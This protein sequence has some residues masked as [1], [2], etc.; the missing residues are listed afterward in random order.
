MKWMSKR[1][2]EAIN[3]LRL[4]MKEERIDPRRGLGEDLF[5]FSSSLVPVVNV[6]LFITNDEKEL[7][8][9]WRDDKFS[10][11]GWH[12]PGGCVR[13]KETLE[14]RIVKTAQDDIGSNVCFDKEPIAVR[15][16]INHEDRCWL[17][18]QLER[19][20][21]ISFLYNCKL[22]EKQS[23][24]CDERIRWFSSIPESLLQQHKILYG[25]IISQFFEGKAM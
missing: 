2:Q 23:V 7:L 4:T 1:I 25:D 10:G 24:I 16:D 12:I 15:E 21:N 19:S 14:E 6:D 5:V 20:H 17:K 9:V 18:N 11:Q 3:N 8:L 22:P 13:L